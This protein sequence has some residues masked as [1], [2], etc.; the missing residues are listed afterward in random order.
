MALING[1]DYDQSL[2]TTDDVVFNTVVSSAG[3]NQIT[4]TTTT[5]LDS[6]YFGSQVVCTNSVGYTVTLP[7]ASGNK[8]K[9]I[10]FFISTTSFAI[11]T[12]APASGVIQGQASFKL[13]SGESCRVMS[14][15]SNYYVMNV[16]LQPLS[17]LVTLSA[18]QT[19]TNNVN[20]KVTFDTV[21]YDV[22]SFYDNVT[23]FRYVPKYPGKYCFYCYLKF[24]GSP[25][26]N[27]N[28]V[29]FQA[30]I[31]QNGSLNSNSWES[32]ESKTLTTT[33]Q[34]TKTF[35]MNGSTDYVEFFVDFNDT[36]AKSLDSNTAFTY[37]GG[38]RINNF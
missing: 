35:T 22:D 17:Y 20:T 9:Y 36:G 25:G 3:Q 4:I 2:K 6:T 11:I 15:G 30:E 13:G 29:V 28:N 12:I 27:N 8:G 16:Y 32:S 34:V 37:A 7:T 14:D 21:Q 5:V 23:N 18:P 33:G 26:F 1:V 38:Y 19:I 31:F 24:S 10:D